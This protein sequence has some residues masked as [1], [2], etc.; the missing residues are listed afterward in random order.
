MRFKP[1]P[2]DFYLNNTVEVARQLLGKTIVRNYGK[3]ILAGKIV[4]TEAYIDKIDPASHS[5][6]GIT[7]RNKPMFEK[8]GIAY[9]YFIY[10]NYYCFNIVTERKGKG[11]AVLI[12]A[13]EPIEGIEYMKKNRGKTKSVYELTNG[14]AKLCL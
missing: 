14:P 3:K 1:L 13:A 2:A 6:P 7:K 4:E 10:G 9:I 11:C 8:G 5:H 12:R